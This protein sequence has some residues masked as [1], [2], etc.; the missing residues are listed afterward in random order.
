MVKVQSNATK[1]DATRRLCEADRIGANIQSDADT[2]DF[3]SYA[4]EMLGREKRRC[5][6]A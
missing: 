5:L 1:L 4:I 3:S 6:N 2:I